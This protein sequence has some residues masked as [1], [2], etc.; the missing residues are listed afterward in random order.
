VTATNN[1]SKREKK[2]ERR[3]HGAK[4]EPTRIRISLNDVLVESSIQSNLHA[5]QLNNLDVTI[6]KNHK[7]FPNKFDIITIKQGDSDQ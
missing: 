6:V 3:Q 7:R 1:S 2:R 4:R 5:T